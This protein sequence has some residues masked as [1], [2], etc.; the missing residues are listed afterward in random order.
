[1]GARY[2]PRFSGTPPPFYKRSPKRKPKEDFTHQGLWARVS[3]GYP[4]WGLKQISY[5][6]LSGVN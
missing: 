5:M 1:M 2:S 6:P 4:V 3:G